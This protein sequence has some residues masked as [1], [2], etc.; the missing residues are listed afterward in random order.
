MNSAGTRKF[1]VN[2][3]LEC[4]HHLPAAT[5]AVLLLALVAFMAV[6]PNFASVVAISVLSDV[7]IYAMLALSLNIILGQCGLFH[8][9][10]AAFFAVGAYTTAIL[11][12]K[13]NMSII[14][15]MPFAGISAG[16]FAF[17]VALPIIHLRGDYLLVVTIAI[18]QIV[19]SALL[20]DV[21]GLTNGANGLIVTE[22]LTIFGISIF[23]EGFYYVIWAG[24][25]VTVL[26]FYFLQN[27]RY[28]RALNYIKYDETAAQGSGVN[29]WLYK[30][31]AFVIGAVWAG[32]VGTVFAPKLM[33]VAPDSFSYAESVVLFTIVILGGAGSIPGVLLG[34]L[35][36]IGLPELFREL[37]SYRMLLFG[38]AMVAMMIFRPQGLIPPM[39]RHYDVSAFLGK[40]PC[41]VGGLDADAGGADTSAVTGVGNANE[42]GA[43]S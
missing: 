40:F 15:T 20:N 7:G 5:K 31:S 6:L 19:R 4:V 23:D 34:A 39:R 35:L 22:P 3:L 13:L 18:V 36:I 14:L 38:A 2:S 28:G 24:V 25:A 37:Q 29:T 1:G 9:G 32:M 10:H 17:L 27:S 30:L 12:S 8:M 42:P 43:G 33:V 21:F 16:L 26:L 41:A 11:S